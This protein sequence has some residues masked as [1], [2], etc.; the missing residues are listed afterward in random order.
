VR[1][2]HRPCRRRND[3]APANGAD[4]HAGSMA[5]AEIAR[6]R[7]MHVKRGP[8]AAPSAVASS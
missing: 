2:N 7:L 8:M 6:R 4:G 3:D 5:M 1:K